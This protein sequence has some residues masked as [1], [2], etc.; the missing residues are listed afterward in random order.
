M[1]HELLF[2]LAGLTGVS[3]YFLMENIALTYISASGRRDRGGG[4]AVHR[5]GRVGRAARET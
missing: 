4:T 5:A 1:A 2:A 3:P